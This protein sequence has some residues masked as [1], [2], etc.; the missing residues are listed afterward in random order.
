MPDE[1]S[2]LAQPYEIVS[3]RKAK[4]PRGGKGSQW[5]R[6]EIVQGSNIIRGYRQGSL[7]IVTRAVEEIVTQLNERRSGR[8]SRVQLV[9]SKSTKP[10]KS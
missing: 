9:M 4:P 2:A 6:Y 3:V 5:Y 1:S 8:S 10:E 7:K